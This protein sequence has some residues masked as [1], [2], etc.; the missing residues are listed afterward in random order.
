MWKRM[1]IP[2]HHFTAARNEGFWWKYSVCISRLHWAAS[3]L[4]YPS[5]YIEDN[6]LLQ[7]LRLLEVLS[8]GLVKG[9]Y[10]HVSSFVCLYTPNRYHR[11]LH[12]D[13]EWTSPR[14]ACH[15]NP[16]RW[17]YFAAYHENSPIANT[18]ARLY[19]SKKGSCIGI[20]LHPIQSKD[21]NGG[22]S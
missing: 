10:A 19:D 21:H 11:L 5:V 6:A 3:E 17:G 7:N 14:V 15:A 22:G 1:D 13:Q 4:V 8:G 12:T 2:S 20:G 9:R 18:W 16:F